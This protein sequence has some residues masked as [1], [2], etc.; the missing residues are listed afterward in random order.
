MMAAA[1]L[2]DNYYND[3]WD[4]V[5]FHR[6]ILEKFHLPTSIDMEQI[7]VDPSTLEGMIYENLKKDKKRIAI[8]SRF[9]LIPQLGRAEI[10]TGIKSDPI[11]AAI[12]SL[13]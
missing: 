8:G 4:R 12:K 13:G 7:H 11:H 9:V 6:Q 1:H 10:I 5:G 2:A 3:G